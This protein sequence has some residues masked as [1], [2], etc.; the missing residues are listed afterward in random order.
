MVSEK[1]GIPK[2]SELTYSG[3][4]QWLKNSQLPNG[5]LESTENGNFVSLYDN[6]LTALLFIE[7]GEFSRAEKIFDFFEARIHSE[8]LKGKGGFFQFRDRNGKNASRRWMGD[9]AW[10]LIALNHYHKATNNTKYHGLSTHLEQWIR[11][12]QD[13][14]GG[15]WGGQQANGA[16]IHKV[17]EGIITA[18]NAVPGYDDFHRNIL[19]YLQQNRWNTKDHLLVSWPTNKA[20]YYAM[21]LHSLGYGIFENF[22]K[23]ALK[24]ADR[25]LNT[26][27]STMTG[28]PLTGY[29]FDEDKDV[30]WFEGTA[31]MA[32]AFQSAGFHA[33]SA[34]I[35]QNLDKAIM[36]NA[37]A[38]IAGIPY[39]SNLGSSYGTSKLWA[40][41]DSTPAISSTVWYLFAKTGFHPLSLGKQKQIPLKDQFWLSK[42]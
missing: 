13:T 20:Y 19:S 42:S 28:E 37:A 26:Q 7:E 29:G 11:S 23:Q 1:E 36:Q 6:A 12:L 27:A 17:T 34:L 9:N 10:L 3:S 16:P 39:A 31:Q 35:L 21:D 5:L 24:D 25:Y 22:P 40:H 14:D 33:K 2:K 32:L 8:L 15:L 4:Y 18:F 38:S 41:A 30:I